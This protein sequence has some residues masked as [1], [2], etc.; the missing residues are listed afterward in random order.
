MFAVFETYLS[1]Q[2]SITSS[3]LNLIQTL[4]VE[5]KISKHRFILREGAIC[6]KAIFIARGLVRLYRVDGEGNEHILR[7]AMENCWISDRESYLT[8][9]PSNANIEAIEDSEV[10]AWKKEDF[11]FLLMQIPAFKQFM[12]NLVEKGQ[13]DSQNRIYSVISTS[14]Q[15]KYFQFMANHPGVFNRVPLHMVASYLGV[16]RETLSR[17]RRHSIGK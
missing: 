10:L 5:Q 15:E 16:S 2:I 7:F 17:I 14:A 4:C 3:E 13:V 12:K 1:K 9:N 11:R 6:D 8:G